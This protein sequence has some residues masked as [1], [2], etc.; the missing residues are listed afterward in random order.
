M[1]GILGRAN[2]SGRVGRRGP[3]WSQC[4]DKLEAIVGGALSQRSPSLPVRV[5]PWICFQ[6]KRLTLTTPPPPPF[7]LLLAMTH[8]NQLISLRLSPSVWDTQRLER[9]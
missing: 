2:G 5:G 3:R 6:G 1:I 8:S 9:Q 4:L 7:K